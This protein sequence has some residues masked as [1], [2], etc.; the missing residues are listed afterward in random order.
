MS[1]CS[2]CTFCRKSNHGVEKCALSASERQRI[3]TSYENA[4]AN[5]KR[6]MEQRYGRNTLLSLLEDIRSDQWIDEHSKRCP[7]CH[8]PTERIDGCNKMLCS[9]CRTNWCWLCTRAIS[10]T[11][12]YNHFNSKGTECFNQLFAGTEEPD[13]DDDENW[14]FDDETE[15]E[16]ES[17]NEAEEAVLRLARVR[18]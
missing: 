4:D 6:L 9:K 17:D 13:T 11:N 12:P 3:L 14:L 2:F 1:L 15:T 5:T 10:D 7:K 16:S 18:L 8:A